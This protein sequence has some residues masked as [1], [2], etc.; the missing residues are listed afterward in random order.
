[1]RALWWVGSTEFLVWEN[2]V[3]E[4]QLV[5]GETQILSVDVKCNGPL[6]KLGFEI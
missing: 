3:S 2:L 5:N 1:M 4:E 6:E